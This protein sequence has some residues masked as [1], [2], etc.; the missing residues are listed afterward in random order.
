MEAAYMINIKRMLY[1]ILSASIICSVFFIS[2]PKSVYSAD[3]EDIILDDKGKEVDFGELYNIIEA[4]RKKLSE[5][6]K[7]L[8][9]Q[10][11]KLEALKSEIS[12]EYK[13]L[14]DIK[15]ELEKEF[16]QK[17]EKDAADIKGIVKLYEAMNPEEAAKAIERM[18]TR[19]AA[20]IIS[21]LNPRKSGKILDA[22][23]TTKVKDI[24]NEMYK[25]QQQ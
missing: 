12:K 13:R 6:E 5:R 19:V 9:E 3:D 20:Q 14:N 24:T 25:K 8:L 2:S 23:N 21:Q 17:E 7:E 15:K 1:L 4:E 10:E 22:M 11:K 18:S 16:S